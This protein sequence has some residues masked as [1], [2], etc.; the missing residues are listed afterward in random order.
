[1]KKRERKKVRKTV[2]VRER[3]AYG[4][5]LVLKLWSHLKAAGYSLS[6]NPLNLNNI[7]LVCLV[8]WKKNLIN[9]TKKNTE[10]HFQKLAMN[11]VN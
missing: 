10:P 11:V 1:M 7:I 5:M 4:Y 9:T 6:L 8:L 3:R 2:S